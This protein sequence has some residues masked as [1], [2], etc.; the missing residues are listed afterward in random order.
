[1]L[2]FQLII[3]YKYDLIIKMSEWKCITF[4]KPKPV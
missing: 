4:E 1:M 3:K 2:C